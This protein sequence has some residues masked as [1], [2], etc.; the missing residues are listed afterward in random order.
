M[1]RIV[2]IFCLLISALFFYQ[3]QADAGAIAVIP[4]NPDTNRP[5]YTEDESIRKEMISVVKEHA[6]YGYTI[7]CNRN[8]DITYGKALNAGYY[9]QDFAYTYGYDYVI[10]VFA[11]PVFWETIHFMHPRA[12]FDIHEV[13]QDVTGVLF[14]RE[15]NGYNYAADLRVN[16]NT[17]HL[18]DDDLPMAVFHKSF[19]RVM[20]N[21]GHTMK[22]DVLKHPKTKV[23]E[24]D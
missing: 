11:Q 5:T 1:K 22:L 3:P 14:S 10:L 21:F 17:E 20:E 7:N 15:W 13:N 16:G 6:P 12:T 24:L 9:R 2:A 8:L 23:S 18:S 19:E 4:M